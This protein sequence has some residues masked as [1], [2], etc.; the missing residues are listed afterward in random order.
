[1][2]FGEGRVLYMVDLLED[3]PEQSLFI[4]E[5]PETSLHEDAQYCLAKYLIDVCNRRHH[6]II[7]STHSSVILDALPS[8][9]RKLLFRDVDGVTE[10]PG[11][12]S[13]R[14]RAVL[15][16]GHQRALTVCVED[17]FA[18]L[19]VTE[20][21]R[22]YEPSLLKAVK[23]VP[24]GSKEAFQEAIRLLKKVGHKAIGIRDGDVG[25][26][27]QENLFSLPGTR[28]PESEVYS[29]RA[30]VNYIKELYGFDLE[31]Y[32]ATNPDTNPHELTKIAASEASVR[33]EALSAIAVSCYA[34]NLDDKECNPIYEAVRK[35]A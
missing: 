20:I 6:Q 13:T 8:D 9:S 11:I 19:V 14:A 12:S 32:I 10:Y 17:D 7:L 1:M 5:E 27:P 2:G 23:I 31:Q 24:I 21:I 29:Q 15:S 26:N 33:P 35:N 25:S 3:A 4:L 18:E 22:R 34:K 28:P 30:V 16:G